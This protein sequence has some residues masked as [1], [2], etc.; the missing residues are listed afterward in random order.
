MSGDL[1]SR[2]GSKADFIQFDRNIEANDVITVDTFL[3]RSTQD[4]ST[5]RFGDS[6]LDLCKATNQRIVNGRWPGDRGNFT[7]VTYNGAS[8]VDYLL[9]SQNNFDLIANFAVK[10]FTTYS[11]HAPI[12][13]SFKI[14]SKFSNDSCRYKEKSY[15][16]FDDRYRELF[17]LDLT[18]NIQSLLNILNTEISGDGDVDTLTSMFTDFLCTHGD[19]YFK[20]SS[21]ETSN[22]CYQVRKKNEEWF[23][24]VCRSKYDTYKKA[25]TQFNLTFSD[26]DRVSMYNAKKDYKYQCR[27]SKNSFNYS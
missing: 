11:N 20:R 7:C 24:H 14:N 22:I 21:H 3:P 5:N 15:Y 19:K 18:N 23:D 26:A 17:T 16:K 2:I 25:V 8:V 13:F 9:T 12:S 10:E 1:N 6:L 27:K 4:G